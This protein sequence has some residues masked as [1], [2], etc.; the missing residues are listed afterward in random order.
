MKR[1]TNFR[2]GVRCPHGIGTGSPITAVSDTL[3]F[4]EGD[5]GIKVGNW[6]IG[7]DRSNMWSCSVADRLLGSSRGF[8]E[9]LG[10]VRASYG[11]RGDAR[12]PQRPEPEP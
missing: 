10:R 1:V 5:R 12:L 7:E 11:P 9:L 6:S 3:N 8:G 4:I 2:V